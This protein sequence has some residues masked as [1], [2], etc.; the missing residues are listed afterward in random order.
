MA[1]NY[2]STKEAIS[3]RNLGRLLQIP[4]PRGLLRGNEIACQEK[5]LLL[6]KSLQLPNTDTI[7]V[8]HSLQGRRPGQSSIASVAIR[9]LFWLWES[10]YWGLYCRV[11]WCLAD[12]RSCGIGDRSLRL[13]GH[14]SSTLAWHCSDNT[15]YPAFSLSCA[16][17][18]DNSS[19]ARP[20]TPAP[21]S[22]C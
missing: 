10:L 11:S 19:S 5:S 6:E 4:S 22:Y 7:N 17:R 20:Y 15:I 18:A 16:V 13:P 1:G 2:G 12:G 14:R 9:H 8:K 21:L 3:N